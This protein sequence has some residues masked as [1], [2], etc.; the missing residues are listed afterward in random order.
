MSLIQIWAGCSRRKVFFCIPFFKLVSFFACLLPRGACL[1]P[2]CSLGLW[3][4]T[5]SESV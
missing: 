2:E 1:M 3:L 4:L 5:A